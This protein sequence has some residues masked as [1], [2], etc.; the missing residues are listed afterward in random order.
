MPFCK[1]R[2]SYCDFYSQT[3]LNLRDEFVNSVRNE[4]K[5]VSSKWHQKRFASIYF[6]GGNPGCLSI[7]SISSILIDINISF[8]VLDEAEITIELN[9]ETINY[10]LITSLKEL[11]F[12]RISLGV[13]S[14]FNSLLT[15]L[16]R[17]HSIEKAE[18]S[19]ELI[20]NAGFK[21]TSIDLMFGIPDL[22]PK[23]W[24]ET[25]QKAFNIGISHISAYLL[26]VE[27][28]TELFKKVNAQTISLPSDEIVSEQYNILCDVAKNYDFE[29]YE[30]SNFSKP[31]YKSVHN[32]LYWFG[33]P[34]LGLGPS[35]HSYDGNNIRSWNI[36]DI[37]QYIAELKKGSIPFE[38]EILNKKDKI[39]DFII[40]SLRTV[41]GLDIDLF[42]KYFGTDLGELLNSKLILYLKSNMIVINKNRI[43]INEP[44]LIFSDRIIRDLMFI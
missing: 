39:N 3:N 23:M 13:Q 18:K 7:E 17:E 25:L 21:N 12:N 14:F 26:S 44:D 35:A 10:N 43:Q 30:I 33:N 37:N 20:K 31:K 22:S 27:E 28:G 19:I 6:G 11:G 36:S 9:P 1:S 40:T 34:Y 41:N 29:H 38:K 5:L 2:C 15:N 8:N 32:R 24:E 16:G 4:I 42:N